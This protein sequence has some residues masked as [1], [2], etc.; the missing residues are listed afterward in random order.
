MTVPIPSI[1]PNEVLVRPV[2]LLA[3]FIPL[4]VFQVKIRACGVCGTDLHIDV[5]DLPEEFPAK[6]PLIP[7]HEPVGTV[8]ATG[9]AV[10]RLQ[11]GQRVVCGANTPCTDCFFCLRGQPLLCSNI[12][13]AGVTVAGAF[14]E[15]AKYPSSKVVPI[16]NLSD[17][18]AVLVEPASCA[19]QM[20]SRVRPEVGSTVLVFGAG[21]AGLLIAQLLKLNGGVRVVVA[22]LGGAKMDLAKTL[23]VGDEFV[24]LE[25]KQPEEEMERLKER[26][27]YGFDVVVEATGVPKVLENSINYVRRGGK[28]AIFGVYSSAARVSWSPSRILGYQIS[29]VGSIAEVIQFPVAVDYLDG[30]KVNVKGITN[31]TFRLEQ[32]GECLESMK[33]GDTV[34][35][36]IVFDE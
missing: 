2:Q 25:G 26:Y 1:S 9:S 34:K 27:P 16:S 32:W 7:G 29:I 35:A 23:G 17:M 6:Y 14:A 20:L 33:E 19:A 3:L 24:V 5:G 21:P 22:S 12:K 36:V 30:G 8:V 4:T 15:Y 11:I 13:C 10:T 18:E 28:L 31:K